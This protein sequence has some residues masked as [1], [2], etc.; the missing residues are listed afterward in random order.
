MPAQYPGIGY[1]ADSQV[2][3]L[4]KICNNTA[5]IVDSGGGGGGSVTQLI[6][7][8]GITLSPP[9]GLGAVTINATGGGGTANGYL[10]VSVS[11]SNTITTGDYRTYTQKITFT[12]AAGARNINLNHFAIPFTTVL[13]TA[14]DKI[15]L[16]CVFPATAGLVI[17]IW[18]TSAQ[19]VKLLPVETFGA[20]QNFT[21]DGNV[22]S[23]TFDF[24]FDGTEWQ[25]EMSNIPA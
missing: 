13:H 4:R 10:E 19:L 22:L 5:L 7:G 11:G 2:S 8:I 12:G 14:G 20:G 15:R 24:V 25:Y 21:T 3:L 16:D 9:T 23:G 18:Q 6:A 1:V 17:T